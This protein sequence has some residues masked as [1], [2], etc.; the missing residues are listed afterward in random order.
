MKDMWKS[1]SVI[2]L[3]AVIAFGV[4]A[5][6]VQARILGGQFELPFDAKW[7]E[8]ALPRGGYT[9]SVDHIAGTIIIYRGSQA[10]G[11]V[12]P[13]TLDSHDN[14]TESPVLVCIR[15]DGKVAVRAL[16]LPRQGTFYFPIPKELNAL[17]AKQSPLIETV[18]IDVSGE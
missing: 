7:G 4:I 12:R 10:M 2:V 1:V 6:D 13:E 17:L 8:V 3:S 15:H 9:F 18:S 11:F 14:P 5:L 16:R